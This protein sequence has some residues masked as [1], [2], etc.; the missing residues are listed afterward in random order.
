M[1]SSDMDKTSPL[2]DYVISILLS[3][4]IHCS[5]RRVGC[6]MTMVLKSGQVTGLSFQ[7]ALSRF[8][9]IGV[10]DVPSMTAC[11]DFAISPNDS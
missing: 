4:K 1:V 3:A 7:G 11:V 9:H 2:R 8:G 10:Y 5:A 6:F